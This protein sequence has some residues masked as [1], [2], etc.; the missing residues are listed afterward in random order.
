MGV[1]YLAIAPPMLGFG[2]SCLVRE[3]GL[4]GLAAAIEGLGSLIEEKQ[5]RLGFLGS[6]LMYIKLPE[7]PGDH[8]HSVIHKLGD[9]ATNLFNQGYSLEAVGTAMTSVAFEVAELMDKQNETNVLTIALLRKEHERLR[10]SYRRE[11]LRQVA[12]GERC[13]E[14]SVNILLQAEA[15]GFTLT[16]EEDG[17]FALRKENC[18]SYHLR[19]NADIEQFGRHRQRQQE[20]EEANRSPVERLVEQGHKHL[21]EGRLENAI[22][23]YSAALRI[24][25]DSAELYFRRG[26]AWKS[27]YY[28]TGKKADDL[29]KAIDDYSRAIEIDPE[30]GQ[31]Y[32]QRSE[33]WPQDQFAE[34]IADY[35]KAIE[36]AHE[37]ASSHY[38]RALLW[39]STGEGWEAKAIA[40]FDAAIRTGGSTDQYMALTGRG[41]LHRNLGNLELAVADFTAAAACYPKSAPSGLYVS[42]AAVLRQLGRTREAIA[43]LDQAIAVASLPLNGAK[44]IAGIYEERGQCRMQLGESDLARQDFERA[45]QLKRRNP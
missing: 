36:Y 8:Y 30:H 41:D 44:F 34:A 13:T 1:S 38:C 17:A 43:D 18:G 22:S 45:A 42:R 3:R 11:R 29:Q 12:T 14:E 24:K 25:P 33:L 31:A 39:Q 9:F 16:I 15:E 21:Q 10:N 2:M 7:Q 19:S 28:N 35:T 20:T 6:H 26:T 5:A 40:D 23:S 37:V 27:T 32:F 4:A